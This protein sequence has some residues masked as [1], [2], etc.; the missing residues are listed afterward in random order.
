VRVSVESL[1]RGDVRVCVGRVE[2]Y[3]YTLAQPTWRVYWLRSYRDRVVVG[4]AI[5]AGPVTF[6]VQ[7]GWQRAA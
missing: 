5:C 4:V 7:R 1:R 3:A 2:W 6:G